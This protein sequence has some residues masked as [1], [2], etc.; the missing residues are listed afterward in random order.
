MHLKRWITSIIILPVVIVLIHW[1]GRFLFAAFILL[2][3]IICLWEYFR[4]VFKSGSR[5]MPRQGLIF[6]YLGYLTACM[7]IWAAYHS[8]FDLIIGIISL[9]LL[10][11]AFFA[12]GNFK[13]NRTISDMAIKQIAG[14]AYI[15]LALAYVVLIRNAYDGVLWVFWAIVIVFAGDTGAFYAGTYLGRHKLAPAVSPNKTVEGALGGLLANIAVG[16]LFKHLFLPLLPWGASLLLFVCVGVAGQIGDLFESL[17]KRVTHI[18]DSG[19]IL[20]GHG[21]FLDRIDAI[22]FAAPVVYYIKEYI[23]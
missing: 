22:L 17:L 10:L 20:P 23:F 11:S 18:K 5:T 13:T 4:I 9:N 6:S 8:S 1:G 3:A 12:V 2:I 7:I 15:P 16:A 14:V 21:G 19:G